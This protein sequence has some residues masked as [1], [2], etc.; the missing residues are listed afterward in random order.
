MSLSPDREGVQDSSAPSAWFWARLQVKPLQI[1]QLPNLALL[2]ESVRPGPG[3][4]RLS[5][6][7]GTA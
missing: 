2:S 7:W 4:Q 1:Q 5:S 6:H 3:K